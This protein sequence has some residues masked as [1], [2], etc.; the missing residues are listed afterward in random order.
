LADDV[1]TE[2]SGAR[3]VITWKQN[4]INVASLV[5]SPFIGI[6]LIEVLCEN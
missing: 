1:W 4:K 6:T 3:E 2:E 5:H